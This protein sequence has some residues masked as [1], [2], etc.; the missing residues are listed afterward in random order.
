M[1]LYN[2]KAHSIWIWHTDNAKT[3]L[4]EQEKKRYS[5]ALELGLSTSMNVMSDIPRHVFQPN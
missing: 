3:L 2:I 5:T 4:L 1:I